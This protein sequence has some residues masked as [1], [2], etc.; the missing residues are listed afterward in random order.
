MAPLRAVIHGQDGNAVP[1]VQ[2]LFFSPSQAVRG[3]GII[4]DETMVIIGREP[5]EANVMVF[6]RVPSDSASFQGIGGLKQMATVPIT[7]KDWSVARVEI[8]P[9][10]FT[11]VHR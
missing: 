5:G 11:L 8:E 9:P 7:V 4:Q 10:S 2:A 1:G 6:V 3:Q